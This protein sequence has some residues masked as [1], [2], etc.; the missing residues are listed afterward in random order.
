M[1]AVYEGSSEEIGV[2]I[3]KIYSSSF[4]NRKELFVT[5]KASEL[6]D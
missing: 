4:W 6:K 1:Q 2:A 5:V 3:R